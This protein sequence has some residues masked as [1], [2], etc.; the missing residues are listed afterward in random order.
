MDLA[1]DYKLPVSEFS[2][3]PT[4]DL[5]AAVGGRMF[6]AESCSNCGTH[7]SVWNPNRGGHPNALVAVWK[8]CRVCELIAQAEDAGPPV[9]EIKGWRIS[10]EHTQHHH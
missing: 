4:D 2:S 7:P 3:W 8:H 9:P 5:D 1:D 6:K 10:L